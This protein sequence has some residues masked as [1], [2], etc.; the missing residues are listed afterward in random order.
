MLPLVQRDRHANGCGGGT[1][2]LCLAPYVQ[3]CRHTVHLICLTLQD[4]MDEVPMQTDHSLHQDYAN[5]MTT[6]HRRVSAPPDPSVGE[7]LPTE[8]CCKST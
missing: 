8:Q 3:A 5:V 1:S 2:P 4:T 6:S 7:L